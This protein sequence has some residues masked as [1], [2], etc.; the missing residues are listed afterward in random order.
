MVDAKDSREVRSKT[1]TATCESR[2]YDGISER[3]RSCP[4]V[5]H[6]VAAA[7]TQVNDGLGC[8]GGS[9]GQA[10]FASVADGG[11]WAAPHVSTVEPRFGSARRGPRA[12]AEAG[13][14]QAA[15]PNIGRRFRRWLPHNCSLTVPLSTGTDLETKSMPM[16]D[17]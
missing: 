4:A 5:S 17:A 3:K 2:M 15:A 13:E 10:R 8:A 14:A 9:V 12:Q 11:P 16:V 7:V 1:M 6:L